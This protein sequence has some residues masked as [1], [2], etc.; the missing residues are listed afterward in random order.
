MER[1]SRVQ[2]TLWPED[3]PAKTSPPQAKE[4][5]SKASGRRCGSKCFEWSASVSQPTSSSKTRRCS[6]HGDSVLSSKDLPTSG[7]MRRGTLYPQPTA[8]RRTSESGC[9]FFVGTPLA[10]SRRR[11]GRFAEGRV[12]NPEEF[13]QMFPT[14]RAQKTSDENLESWMARRDAGKVSTPPL[15][16]A[17]RML[18]TPTAQDAKCRSNPSQF[19]RQT[20]P[21]SAL[22]T[23]ML[24][25]PTV[26]N[27]IACSPAEANRN[28]PSLAFQVGGKLNPEWV[29]W[30]MGWP[31]GW[32]SFA[33]LAMD[34][35]QSW[36]QQHSEC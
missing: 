10:T 5:D 25:T 6:V 21:L 26:R 19:R 9:G 36:L 2:L 17:V 12:P 7:L 23:R 22:V 3:F 20:V 1:D 33:P 4:P 27:L 34:K 8:V 15:A 30:L 29:A 16:L 32:A 18:P 35:F 24:P 28:E 13:V 31:I 14:P 11:S